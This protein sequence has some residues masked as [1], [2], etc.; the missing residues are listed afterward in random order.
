MGLMLTSL[1]ASLDHHGR[2]PE[3]WPHSP[4]SRLPP[5][6]VPH[7]SEVRD[8]AQSA[9]ALQDHPLCGIQGNQAGEALGAGGAGVGCGARVVVTVPALAGGV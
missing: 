1:A 8:A 2:G 6:P 3:A 9:H 4:F 7:Q 5:N